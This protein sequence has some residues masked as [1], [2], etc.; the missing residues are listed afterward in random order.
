LH[1]II[2]HALVTAVDMEKGWLAVN[3][4]DSFK[5]ALTMAWINIQN[6]I[7]KLN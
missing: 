7:S 3:R 5:K 6:D 1:L 2:F 4:D